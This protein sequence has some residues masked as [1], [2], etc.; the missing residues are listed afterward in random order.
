MNKVIITENAETAIHHKLKGLDGLRGLSI[1]LVIISH[2]FFDT[3]LNKQTS[4]GLI[5]V[6]IFFVISGFLITTL[7]LKEKSVYQT[8]HL[9]FFFIRRALRILPVFLLFLSVVFVLNSIF[10]LGISRLNF[11]TSILFLK[12]LP[13]QTGIEW[14]TGHL[15]SLCVEEQFYLIFPFLIS[16]LPVNK[17]RKLLILLI[18]AFTIL[19]FLLYKNVGVF[20]SNRLVHLVSI[21]LVNLFSM[22][23]VL[24]ITGSLMA[25]LLF[26]KWPFIIRLKDVPT[27]TSI[28]IF[29]IALII[30][31]D[32]FHLNIPYFSET[33]F[34]ILISL[35]IVINL[36]EKAWMSKILNSKWLTTIGIYSYGAYLW[37]QLFTHNQPWKNTFANSDSLLFNLPLLILVT[38]LCYQLFEKKF[39][40]LKDRFKRV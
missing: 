25:V 20:Y 39:L 4:I 38:W 15:W 30:R 5:G 16:F 19:N 35:V 14:Y 10:H 28:F 21:V 9:R 6:Q 37:Q 1:L 3:E 12:N 7:L 29:L 31:I 40:L 22:G 32:Y 34:G 36:N 27:F 26:E 23:T 11:I 8:I 13:I 17:Y 18:I 24:I 33:V 2:I